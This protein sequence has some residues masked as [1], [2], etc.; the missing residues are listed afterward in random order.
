MMAFIW[1]RQVADLEDAGLLGLDQEHGAL[2]DPW[3]SR[4][5]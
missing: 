1:L 3:S 5:R 4:W 2:L